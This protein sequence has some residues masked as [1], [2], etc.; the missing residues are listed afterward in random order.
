[1]GMPQDALARAVDES[2]VF[3]VY[4]ARELIGMARV[5]TDRATY[6]YLTDV[7]IL[8]TRR[9]MGLG[10]WL[11]ECV[12]DHPDLQT[13]RR[14]ALLTAEAPWLYEKFGF[15]PLTGPSVYMEIKGQ[16]GGR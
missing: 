7:V 13:L 12:L 5:V 3:G 4:D 1:M 8:K 10:R 16:I 6:G 11:V 2:I 14:L 9:G 15:S